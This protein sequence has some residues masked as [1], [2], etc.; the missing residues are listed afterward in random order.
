MPPVVQRSR[1]MVAGDTFAILMNVN[2][3][4]HLLLDCFDLRAMS[5]KSV[6]EFTPC[7]RRNQHGEADQKTWEHIVC[8]RINFLFAQ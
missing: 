7:I 4:A 6:T 1:Q 8:A 2:P 3:V 5:A